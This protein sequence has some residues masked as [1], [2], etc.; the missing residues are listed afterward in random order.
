MWRQSLDPSGLV[1]AA[2]S[3]ACL[4]FQDQYKI[5]LLNPKYRIPEV[6]GMFS[7]FINTINQTN[8]KKM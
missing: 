4:Q 1:E 5:K 3:P 6:P 8:P 7:S 2:L